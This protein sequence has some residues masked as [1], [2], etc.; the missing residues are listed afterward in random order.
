[1][2]NTKIAVSV[3]L[4]C[5]MVPAVASATPV[6]FASFSE[7]NPKKKDFAFVNSGRKRNR[8]QD[9]VLFSTTDS[10]HSGPIEV[11]F[12][13]LQPE[14]HGMVTNVL[15]LFQY[16]ATIAK[17]SPAVLTGSSFVQPGLAGA[18]SFT[19]ETP[20]TVDG[21]VYGIGANLLSGVFSG[22]SLSGM[23]K[24][25]AGVSDTSTANG[26]MV[27]FTSAFLDFSHTQNRDSLLTLA[28]LNARFSLQTNHALGSFR[29]NISGQFSSS[30]APRVTVPEPANIALLLSGLGMLGF[31]MQRGRAPKALQG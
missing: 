27:T 11:K 2:V 1:M 24:K 21:I 6:V 7:I 26:A 12:S 4:A 15:A 23:L 10:K 28:A 9:A 8:T 16:D 14:F 18:F 20:I 29:S 25:N 31:A 30:P 13:F 17:G 19:S 3:A 22:G 5:L